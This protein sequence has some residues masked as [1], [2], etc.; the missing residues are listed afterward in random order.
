MLKEE[1]MA[2]KESLQE[3]SLDQFRASDGFTLRDVFI[4]N[5]YKADISIK[6]TL[7]QAPMVSAL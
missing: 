5:L 6:R 7:F 2:I 3:S 1:V 4:W